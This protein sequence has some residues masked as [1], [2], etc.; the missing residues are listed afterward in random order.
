M[1][2]ICLLAEDPSATTITRLCRFSGMVTQGVSGGCTLCTHSI[3]ITGQP[4]FSNCTYADVIGPYIMLKVASFVSY[5][6]CVYETAFDLCAD[7]TRIR[8]DLNEAAGWHVWLFPHGTPRCGHHWNL[9]GLRQ[10][11]AQ[12]KEALTGGPLQV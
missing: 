7:W 12:S 10:P 8:G 3:V 4:C 9:L 6:S 11:Q 2:G 1:Q 5:R